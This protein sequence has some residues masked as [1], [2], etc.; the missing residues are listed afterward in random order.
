MAAIRVGTFPRCAHRIAADGT[1]GLGQLFGRLAI[2]NRGEAAM[3]LIHAVRELN[4]AGGHQIETIALYT[5]AESTAKF[6]RESDV[7]YRLGPAA[8]RPYLNLQ[9]LEQ[10]LVATRAD[11]AWVGW[12]FVAEQPEFPELCQRLGITFIG[13]SAAAMRSLGDKIGSKLLA[14][15]VGVPVAPWSQGPVATLAEAQA[16]AARLGFPLMLKAT[17]G[18]GGRG[19]RKVGSPEELSAVFEPTSDEALRAFGS[20]VMFLESLVTGARHVEVQVIADGQGTAW[21]IGVRDCSIQRRNQKIIEE[22]A[23]AVL[24]PEQAEQVKAAAERLAIAV[25][26]AGAGTVEFLYQPEQKM[27]A[28][29]EVNTRLQVEHPITELVTNTDLVKLQLHVAAGGKLEGERPTELGHAVEARLNAEDPDREFAPAPGRIELLDLPAGPGVRVDTGFSEGDLIP[30]D[31]DSMIAKIIAYGPTRDAALARLRRAVAETTVIIEG[32]T[33]NKSFVLELLDQPAVIDASADTGWIDR[34]RAEGG[35]VSHRHAGVALVAAAIQAYE[36]AEDAE[37]QHFLATAHGGR[38]QARHQFGRTIELKLR[39]TGYKLQV[40][41]L[42]PARFR[43]GLQEE[44]GLRSVDA[45]VQRL[46]AHRSRLTIGAQRF[47][48]VSAT[49]GTVN[50][51]EVEGTTHRITRDEGGVLRSPAPA[52]VV[53]VPVAVGDE[54]PAGAPVLVLESMKMETVLT[55]PFPARVRSLLVTAGGQVETGM[56]MIRLEPTGDA[57]AADPVQAHAPVLELPDGHWESPE[58]RARSLLGDLHDLLLGFDLTDPAETLAEYQRWRAELAEQTG[59]V[60]LAEEIALF[61]AF[62]DLAELGRNRPGGE[63][64]NG[65][66]VHS[67]REYFHAYLHSLDIDR[68]QLPDSFRERLSRA[69]R[70]YGVTEL[71]RTPELEE[72]VYRIFLAQPGTPSHQQLVTGLLQQW[73]LDPLPAAATD[74]VRD[75]LD[76]LV[77]ATQLRYP[78]VGDLARSARFRWFEQPIVEAA[79][80]QVLAGVR[81]ELAYLAA[82]PQAPDYTERMD[83]LA[84]IPERIVQFLA[85]RLEAGAGGHEPMLEVLARRH[86]REYELHDLQNFVAADRPIVACDYVL[87]GRPSHLLTTVAQREELVAGAPLPIALAEQLDRLDPD[88][89]GVIDLYLSWSQMPDAP[90]EASAELQRA[91]AQLGLVERVRRIAV[92][93]VPGAGRPVT[94]FTFRPDANAGDGIVEDD[95]VRGVHPMVGRRLNLWRLRDFRITRLDAPDDVLLYLA[96]APENEADQ[97]LVALAQIRDLS[98]VRDSAGRVVSMPQAERAVAACGEAIRRARAAHGGTRLDMNLVSLQIWPVIDAPLDELT[99]LQKTISPLTVGAGIESVR[100]EGRILGPDGR[101]HEV[102]ATFSF[103]PG[104]GV[105][106][107][108]SGPSKE[109]L[110]PLDD[111]SQKVLR[112]RRRGNVYPYELTA[113]IAGRRGTFTEYDL[114]D[115]GNLVPVDREPGG[116]KAGIVVGVAASPTERHPEGVTRVVLLGDPTRALGAVSEPEC[117][118]IIAA[119]DLAERMQ[120]PVEWFALSA[121]ARIAMNSGTEN[122]DW[123]ARALR[124]IVTF[125][126]AGGE[127]NVVVAGINVGAQPYWN[128]EATMLMHT[129]GILVMTPDSAMVLTGKQSLDFSGGVSAEDNFGIGG[130]DRVMGPN[131]QAQYWVANLAAACDL[132]AEHYAYSYVVPGETAPRPV[133]TSD[134]ADRDITDYPHQHPDSEFS[135]VGE[136]FATSTNPDRKKP[137]DIRTLMRA[138]ADQDLPVL[139]RWA[140]M[141]EAETSVVFDAHLGGQPVCLI[142]IESRPIPRRGFPPSDGPDIWTA[143][144]LFPRSSKKTARAINAASGNRPVVVLANLSGFD[145][146]PDSMRNLQLEYGAEIGRA[147]VNFTGPIVFCVVSRYH[148]GAFVVFSK[149]LNENMRV[150]AVDGSFASVIGGAPAAAVVFAADVDKRTARDARVVGLQEQVA[151]EADPGRRAELLAEFTELRAAVRVEKLAEVATEFDTIH[152][153]R[154]AVEVGSVDEVV[155]PHQLR[156]RLIAA[157]A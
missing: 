155:Q 107:T 73:L 147:I 45:R 58:V 139:E 70:H 143:G 108:V 42:G 80:S 37:R 87:D 117:A 57:A 92:A 60:P 69:L 103:Q 134:A 13:P 112:A 86:Y 111:Y 101:V 93:V 151:A 97:R 146:S 104:A 12:G 90:N 123:I 79:R 52:L 106:F 50:L 75:T 22:S 135:T 47:K 116:N 24:A 55:A 78:V 8:E 118:R 137:F 32:G 136:I 17:A 6:V 85:E 133:P 110:Q 74:Q 114:D 132:L 81:D 145:G 23:S 105:V 128:A 51:V 59:R 89:E 49:H 34:V 131:G 68:E 67:P 153:I 66:R 43:V 28:F 31:F 150:L 100:A 129:K 91:L 115:G 10:A 125:T 2:I 44:G 33:T 65:D 77:A 138:V 7:A 9:L 41:Q 140:D 130:Y 53:A 14:E 144:T 152:S 88:R 30:A 25:G 46:D 76:R 27:F 121:G 119:L 156:P 64:P 149:A 122:M 83:G 18:G 141:A 96:V 11:A 98:L 19:I 72:A 142:G 56:P 5:D 84:A 26:Y 38:P 16:Q 54:V 109:R 82:H 39:G 15:Q 36:V 71:D 40:A 124:R 61:T 48:L 157:L 127:I 126:Q 63:E 95:L 113:M 148:G 94:Y 1:E 20:G 4:A 62:A 154:R 102:G 120:V 21:A 29:L 99:A 35:L 3:R